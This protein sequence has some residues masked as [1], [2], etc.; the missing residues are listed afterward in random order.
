M[1]YLL[2]FFFSSF[3]LL[4]AANLSSLDLINVWRHSEIAEKNS[5][6]C[7]IGL[8]PVLFDD[9]KLNILPVD[10]RIEYLP[11]IPLPFSLGLFFKTPNPN[12][13][14]FGARLAYHFDL[15]DSFTDLYIVYSYD[16]G[17]LR[18]DLLIEYNDTPVDLLLYDFRIG[19]RRFF[20]SWFGISVETGFHFESVIFLLSIKIN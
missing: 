19:V 14:S 1:K 5:V 16:F 13:K 6:F 11:P 7:D 10:I 17:Y 3:L 18:N 20:D 8:S 9:L 4:S 12:L 15:F 2:S